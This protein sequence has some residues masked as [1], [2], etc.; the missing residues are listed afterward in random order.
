MYHRE[1][2]KTHKERDFVFDA[3]S[4]QNPATERLSSSKSSNRK[5]ELL[6]IQQEKEIELLKIQQEKEIEL[7]KIQQ[8]KE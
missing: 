1:R 3:I 8:P 2:E 4:S 6:K 7:L 5:I